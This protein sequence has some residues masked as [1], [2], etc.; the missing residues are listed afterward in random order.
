MGSRYMINGKLIGRVIC[1]CRTPIDYIKPGRYRLVNKD[2]MKLIK[3]QYKEHGTQC[4]GLGNLN[5]MKQVN[6]GGQLISDMVKAD[7]FLKDKGIKVWTGDTMTA[8]KVVYVLMKQRPEA[9]K[10]QE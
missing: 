3:S 9:L 7:P 10:A 5:K 6:D 8:A 4:F 1:I 2:I